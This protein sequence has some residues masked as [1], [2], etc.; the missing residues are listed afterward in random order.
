MTIDIIL[1]RTYKEKMSKVS[2]A[3]NNI[4]VTKYLYLYI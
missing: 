4:S 1:Q 2:N 3:K